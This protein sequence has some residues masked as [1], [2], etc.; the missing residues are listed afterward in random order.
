MP[1][2]FLTRLLAVVVALGVAGATQLLVPA[3]LFHDA[4]PSMAVGTARADSAGAAQLQH[5]GPVDA[6]AQLVRGDRVEAAHAAK[7][8]AKLIP[9]VPSTGGF[10][11]TVAGWTKTIFRGGQATVDRC[12]ATLWY[13]PFPGTRGRRTTWLA[14]HDYCGFYRWDKSLHIGSTFTITSPK[15]HVMRYRV[16]SRGYVNRHSGSSNGL[17]KGDVMLQTCHGSSTSFT[18]ARRIH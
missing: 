12:H 16:F 7:P 1:A 4:A 9:T 18:Y 10:G 17:I 15:G 3:G 5:V 14:G 8:A 13:G 11:V 6:A 2:R